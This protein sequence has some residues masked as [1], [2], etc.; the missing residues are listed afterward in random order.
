MKFIWRWLKDCY[1]TQFYTVVSVWFLV[2]I[3]YLMEIALI[4]G[5]ATVHIYNEALTIKVTFSKVYIVSK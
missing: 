1:L 2:Y 5:A 3:L 4:V